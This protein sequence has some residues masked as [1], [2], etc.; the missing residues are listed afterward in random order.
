MRS[1]EE[2][3]NYYN[4]ALM[5][6][7]L[8]LEEQ[9]KRVLKKVCLVNGIVILVVVAIAATLIINK[10]EVQ[11][12]FFLGFVGIV[13]ILGVYK[14]LSRDYVKNFKSGVIEK[15]VEFIDP[16]LKYQREA[17]I[18]SVDF[19]KSKIFNRTP[20]RHRGDDYVSGTIGK[21]KIEFS[22]IHSE[23]VTRNSK[24][25]SQ[26]HTI[27]KG[28]FFVG[29]FNKHFKGI[30]VVLPDTVEKLFGGFGNFLQKMNSSKG[31][32]IKLEDAEF[33][34]EFAVY[35]GDQVEARYI[36]ST[37]LMKRIVDFKKKTGRKIF[38]SFVGS[39]IY[40]AISFS[41]D[42]F[43]PRVFKTIIDFEQVIE[44]YQDLELAIGIVEDLNLNLRIW[45]KE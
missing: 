15:I 16:N 22:E 34:K 18:P 27:F 41:K 17:C 39:K 26:W 44:Y 25:R 32:L 38:M 12:V 35:S 6:E 43:E 14:W 29:D 2:L 3:G 13:A 9:R 11:A 5:P 31:N 24:G 33:E 40:V 37:S 4:T 36:L 45:T 19:V 21:T 10:I 20:D 7:L 28:L 8:V 30:T 42:L 23:Y 1:L